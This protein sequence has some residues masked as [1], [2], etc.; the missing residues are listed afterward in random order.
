MGGADGRRQALGAATRR[1]AADT[2]RRRRGAD[3]DDGTPP[4]PRR[5][6]WKPPRPMPE[7]SSSARRSSLRLV[8]GVLCARAVQRKKQGLLPRQGVKASRT[9]NALF[10]GR[11]TP[12]RSREPVTRVAMPPLIA[13]AWRDV[14]C[15]R[16]TVRARVCVLTPCRRLVAAAAFAAS[17]SPIVSLV[18]HADAAAAARAST[19]SRPHDHHH[20]HDITL[21]LL[22]EERT[23]PRRHQQQRR[24]DGLL[25]IIRPPDGTPRAQSS[26][27]RS[28]LVITRPHVQ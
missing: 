22:R 16:A 11:G 2:A 27:A 7:G 15:E 1:A 26:R 9:P 20:H 10:G 24:H 21:T 8:W 19:T 18:D 3:D 25:F 28:D 14:L 23:R 5:A 13:V 4:L 6:A 12:G 17:R